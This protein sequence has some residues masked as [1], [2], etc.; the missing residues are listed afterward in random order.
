MAVL[1]SDRSSTGLDLLGVWFLEVRKVTRWTRQG[2]G[3]LFDLV[4]R[5][6]RAL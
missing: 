4:Q 3:I 2:R 6:Q 1:H 5:L